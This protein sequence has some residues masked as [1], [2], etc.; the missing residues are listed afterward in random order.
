MKSSLC[1]IVLAM[2][3]AA[4]VLS[5]NL[6]ASDKEISLF[7]RH[8]PTSPLSEPG[9]TSHLED[10]QSSLHAF[11]IRKAEDVRDVVKHGY[12]KSQLAIL[13]PYKLSSIKLLLRENEGFVNLTLRK[14]VITGLGDFVVKDV[15]S[16]I[17]AG[18]A[19]VLLSYPKVKITGVYRV[20]GFLNPPFNQTVSDDGV[21]EAVVRRA[22]ATWSTYLSPLNDEEVRV[23]QTDVSAFFDDVTHEF[24]SFGKMDNSSVSELLDTAAAALMEK[25]Q[26]IIEDSLT[27]AFGI[28]LTKSSWTPPPKSDLFTHH[29][30]NIMK[31]QVPCNNGEEL[32][33][34]VTT[35]L[36]FAGRIVRLMEPIG[37]PNMTAYIDNNLIVFFYNGRAR[38]ASSL[39][40]R[41]TPYVFCPNNTITLGMVVGFSELKIEASYR[42]M[43]DYQTLLFNGEAEIKVTDPVSFVQL[44]QVT[45]PDTTEQTL[46]RLKVWSIGKIQVLLKGLGN[47]TRAVSMLLTQTINEDP[48]QFIN[49]IEEQLTNMLRYQLANISVPLFSLI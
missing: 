1:V 35:L 3:G 42:V 7:T 46:D 15:A 4:V 31:R 20:K 17:E 24:K 23:S 45:L 44:T 29:G 34:Y 39:S 2:F 18:Q 48:S 43:Q 13:D 36:S 47:L 14:A 49:L 5:N 21:F 12:F 25:V 16:N 19:S 40:S 38:G 27:T 41:K 26:K 11:L 32:D 10:A 37:F 30:R 33:E 9:S 22:G 28:S 6:T 8:L